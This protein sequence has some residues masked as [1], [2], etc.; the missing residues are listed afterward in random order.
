MEPES[1]IPEANEP[2]MLKPGDFEWLLTS[3]YQAGSQGADPRGFP[4]APGLGMAADPADYRQRQLAAAWCL[5]EIANAAVEYLDR[6]P[7]DLQTIIAEHSDSWPVLLRP[8]L[9]SS[10]ARS[11]SR[12]GGLGLARE[13]PINL[14]HARASAS[15][16]DGPVHAPLTPG[17]GLAR[18]LYDE[19]L[20]KR[21]E[22]G[23]AHTAAAAIDPLLVMSAKLED[24]AEALEMLWNGGDPT[25]VTHPADLGAKAAN[26][27]R[28][29]VKHSPNALH[30][31]K[32]RKDLQFH[33][34][35]ATLPAL[36]ADTVKH[37]ALASIRFLECEN[38]GALVHDIGPSNADAYRDEGLSR[39]IP[40]AYW[41][42]VKRR[43]P[44]RSCNPISQLESDVLEALRKGF[45]S[46]VKNRAK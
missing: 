43:A 46:L 13:L 26:A 9:S 23:A 4:E 32:L 28:K 21:E 2:P 17:I 24:L 31:M 25:G 30:S 36:R 16:E 5:R 41:S 44:K 40:Q 22:T 18:S 27:G 34:L 6:L 37:W 20:K 7:E 14:N 39:W 15:G 8:K 42:S 35:L 19:L 38:R 33:C 11:A 45:G 1:S 10:A 29:S 12:V 3:I